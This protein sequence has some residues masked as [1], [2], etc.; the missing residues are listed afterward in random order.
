MEGSEFIWMFLALGAVV[1]IFLM[2][3]RALSD[4]NISRVVSIDQIAAE[5]KIK[6]GP[7]VAGI[8]RQSGNVHKELGE[9][10]NPEIALSEILKSLRRAQ[11]DSVILVQNTATELHF[12]RLHRN[13]R[14][15]SGKKVGGGIIRLV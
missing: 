2:K 3:E 13:V 6:R 12:E 8:F 15:S 11:I 1:L 4:P 7:V 14:K 9:F 5:M 10:E